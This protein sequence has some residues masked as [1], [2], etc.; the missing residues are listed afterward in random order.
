M[1]FKTR[2]ERKAALEKMRSAM[3]QQAIFSWLF[4][5]TPQG[6]KR[7]EDVAPEQSIAPHVP[8]GTNAILDR[9]IW[10][11]SW[12]PMRGDLRLEALL[13]DPANNAPLVP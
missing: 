6:L 13:S 8:F 7:D 1:T 4:E 2:A 9:G 3:R 5:L 10:S 11:G 12:K